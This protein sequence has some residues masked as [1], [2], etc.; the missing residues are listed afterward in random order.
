MTLSFHAFAKETV[1]VGSTPCNLLVSKALAVTAA[2][3]F[4]KWKLNLRSDQSFLLSLAY[5]ESQPNTNE[6]KQGGTQ[7]ELTGTYH[8][9]AD[10]L[11]LQSTGFK[12]D[13]ILIKLDENLF[14]FV[15]N[16]YNLLVGDG[17][18]SFVLNR[19]S[20]VSATGVSK[21][22]QELMGGVFDGRTPC[23]ELSA[24]LKLAPPDRSCIKLKWRLKFIN[25]DANTGTFE[26][27]TTNYRSSKSL[28]GS[29]Q[30]KDGTIEL[31]IPDR[32]TVLLQKADDNVLLFLN[33]QKQLRV[34]NYDFSYALNRIPGK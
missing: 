25:L 16:K 7:L 1:Y 26:L 13:L 27:S 23:D 5:G 10:R 3:E 9:L 30:I 29:W 31:T 34:G 8:M 32:G 11:H 18:F 24:Q 21:R 28:K 2:C 19:M 20:S 6:F 4:M 12:S 15:D 33:P 17:G 22:G 14:H